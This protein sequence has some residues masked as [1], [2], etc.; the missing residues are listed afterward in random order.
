MHGIG[1]HVNVC[2]I[3]VYFNV[4]VQTLFTESALPYLIILHIVTYL[5][6]LLTF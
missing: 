6:T 3:M 4:C 2:P 1:T 5:S